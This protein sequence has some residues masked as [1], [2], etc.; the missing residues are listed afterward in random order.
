M[1]GLSAAASV[2]AVLQ[3]SSVF[4]YVNSAAGATKER[5]RLREGVRACE[6]VLQQLKD[7][8]DDSELGKA[9]LET[10]ETL[11]APDAPLGR[12][13]LALK[14]L[15]AK[16]RPKEGLKNALASL[17][18]PF[19]EKEIEVFLAV[20][21]REK[22]LLEL[23]LSNNCRKLVQEIKKSSTQ[24]NK[25]LTD[26]IEA[27]KRHS[28]AVDSNAKEIGNHL[29]ELTDGLVLIQSSQAG[30]HDGLKPQAFHQTGPY[31]GK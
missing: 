14:T 6:S 24:N 26:L 29:G 12:L 5:Q 4:K 21:E 10:I 31:R 16:L 1:D 11:E 30:L 3:L 7:Q 23:A 28:K 8:T 20:I 9:W 2:I 17:K 27:V 19:N 15:K 22:S 18:W 13:H 25:Q